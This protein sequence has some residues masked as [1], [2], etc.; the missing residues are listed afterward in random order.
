[1]Q[2]PA[3]THV[4]E[5]SLGWQLVQR[6]THTGSGVTVLVQPF[7]QS[8][9]QHDDAPPFPTPAANTANKL[10]TLQDRI[11][12]LQCQTLMA[13]LLAQEALRCRMTSEQLFAT[14]LEG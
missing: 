11:M 10:Q 9:H 3:T 5:S 4:K 14:K 1:M 8:K 6:G 13:K 7:L 12:S 2:A